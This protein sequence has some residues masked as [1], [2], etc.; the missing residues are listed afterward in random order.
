M[1]RKETDRK[2]KEEKTKKLSDRQVK[3]KTKSIT[4]NKIQAD[5]GKLVETARKIETGVKVLGEKTTEVV[6]KVSDQ[7]AEF[8]EKVYDKFKKGVHDAYDVGSKSIS[9]MRKKTGKYI[10]KYEDTFEVKSLKNDRDKKMHELGTHIFNLYKS[11]SQNLT[12]L[13]ANDVSKKILNEIELLE[14]DI[15]KLSKRIKRKI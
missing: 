13:I 3:T 12:D 10:Q 9:D 2:S 5:E 7:T 8:T 14:K 6:E 1:N 4:K 15:A 11:K